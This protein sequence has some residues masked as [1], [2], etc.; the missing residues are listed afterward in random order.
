MR[1]LTT[2][3]PTPEQSN[4]SQQDKNC[5][6]LPIFIKS[7]WLPVPFLIW[8]RG[9]PV[10][11]LIW[12]RILPVPFLIW[13]RILP[14]PLLIWV[15]F[16]PVSLLIWVRGLCVTFLIWISVILRMCTKWRQQSKNTK[17]S[18]NEFNH[19]INS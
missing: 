9:L 10:P 6:L 7:S 19:Q 3:I 1:K 11:F 14:V 8:V 5:H 16:L 12:V 17:H 2:P 15:R 4:S 13:V 18:K